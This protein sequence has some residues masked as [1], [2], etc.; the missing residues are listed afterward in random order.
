MAVW[1]ADTHTHI[2][3]TWICPGGIRCYKTMFMSGKERMKKE[4]SGGM[5]TGVSPMTPNH[6][7]SRDRTWNKAPWI[8]NLKW[9]CNKICIWLKECVPQN[10]KAKSEGHPSE[11]PLDKASVSGTLMLDLPCSMGRTE[12]TTLTQYLGCRFPG[13]SQCKRNYITQLSQHYQLSNS[14][15]RTG[16]GRPWPTTV[17]TC[18]EKKEFTPG[19]A[20]QTRVQKL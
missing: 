9:N 11:P 2:L 3:K 8:Q 1:R 6:S 20:P 5:Q 18:R 15:N 10:E 4:H 14:K 17:H 16:T 12:R 19:R 13:Y 7:Q